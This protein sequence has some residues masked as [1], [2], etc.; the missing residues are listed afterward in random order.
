[1][2]KG[3]LVLIAFLAMMA[4]CAQ[5]FS[6]VLQ[7]RRHQA[8]TPASALLSSS[9]EDNTPVHH[10]AIKTRDI[11]MAI[12]FYSLLDFEVETKFLAGNVRAAWLQQKASGASG[13]RIELI[14]IP[15]SM[16]NEPDGRRRR[17]IDLVQRPELLGLNHYAIDVTNSMNRKNMK[18]LEQWVE[19]LNKKSKDTFGKTLRVAVEP[20][21]QMIGQNLY[22]LAFIYDADGAI[23]E[24]IYLQR[25][26][27]QKMISGWYV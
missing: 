8:A 5:A 23:I 18:Q 25:K 26:F 6:P 19:H 4:H 1:M 13:V 2:T 9:G 10:T 22:Q 15:S 12:K 7:Q 20:F 14:E 11:E 21:E 24:L 16:L 3:A 27:T 17:A